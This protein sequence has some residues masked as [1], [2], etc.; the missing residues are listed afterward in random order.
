MKSCPFCKNKLDKVSATVDTHFKCHYCLDI[1]TIV[2]DR[3]NLDK[4]YLISFISQDRKYDIILN[5]K[6]EETYIYSPHIYNNEAATLNYI[7]DCTPLNYKDKINLI[8]TFQ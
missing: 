2:Y 8:L 3:F 6:D 7:L 1:T 4:I 5:L